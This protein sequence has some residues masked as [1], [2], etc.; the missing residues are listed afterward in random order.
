[1][2]TAIGAL[3][4]EMTSTDGNNDTTQL[5]GYKASEG[6]WYLILNHFQWNNASYNTA[7][8]S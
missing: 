8:G 5:I 1:M 3:A 6:C 7:V 4:L 2:N